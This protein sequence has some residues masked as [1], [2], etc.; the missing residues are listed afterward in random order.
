MSRPIRE[1]KVSKGGRNPK[2]STP[3]PS[4]TPQGQSPKGP[5]KSQKE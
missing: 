4:N 5:D 1:G 2:P 3:R